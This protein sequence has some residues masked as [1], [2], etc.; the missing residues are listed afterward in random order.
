MSR[1]YNIQFPEV[2]AFGTDEVVAQEYIGK[3]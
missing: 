3:I 2:M 1:L